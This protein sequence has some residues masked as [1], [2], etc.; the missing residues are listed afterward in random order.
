[1]ELAATICK[2][3]HL[4]ICSLTPADSDDQNTSLSHSHHAFI[5]IVLLPIL[6]PDLITTHRP[7]PS[8]LVIHRMP[9]HLPR[10]AQRAPKRATDIFP[11]HRH[12][13]G[14]QSR[15]GRTIVIATATAATAAYPLT[16][17]IPTQ[18]HFVQTQTTLLRDG[19]HVTQRRSKLYQNVGRVEKHGRADDRIESHVDVVIARFR[20][21]RRRENVE[22]VICDRQLDHDGKG[23]FPSTIVGV[24]AGPKAQ[25]RHFHPSQNLPHENEAAEPRVEKVGMARPEAEAVA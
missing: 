7:P 11:S 14:T 24:S 3:C 15:R 13:A 2:K 16:R 20:I 5:R 21:G 10:H 9:R 8:L 17:I 18:P 6:H 4:R 19:V 22:D 1:M 23:G 12:A 25:P